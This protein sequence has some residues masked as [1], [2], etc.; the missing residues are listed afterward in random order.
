MA[1]MKNRKLLAESIVL[2]L[3][4]SLPCG[5]A[6]AA[7]IQI[8]GNTSYSGP[9]E[10][11]AGGVRISS[12][13]VLSGTKDTDMVMSGEFSGY[14]RAVEVDG[15]IQTAKSLMVNGGTYVVAGGKISGIGT[16]TLTNTVN[17]HSGGSLAESLNNQGT[18]TDVDQL[19]LGGYVTNSGTISA[20]S[21]AEAD[22][23]GSSVFNI[24]NQE[25]GSITV[26]GTANLT[27]LGNKGIFNAG[28]INLDTAGNGIHNQVNGKVTAGS[29]TGDGYIHNADSSTVDADC[30]DV[31]EIS[32]AAGATIITDAITANTFQNSGTVKASAAATN[33]VLGKLTVGSF[34][35][36]ADATL[37]VND[38]TVTDKLVNSGTLAVDKIG[39]A[40]HAASVNN[41]TG[42]KLTVSGDVTAGKFENHGTA[43]L[44]TISADTVW[45]GGAFTANDFNAKTSVTNGT[46]GNMTV[47]KIGSAENSVALTNSENS[48]ITVSG[49]VYGNF[50][51]NGTMKV[52]G[53]VTG[54]GYFSRNANA[55]LEADKL[56]VTSGWNEINGTVSVNNMDVNA[57][58]AVLTDKL[59]VNDT[60]NVSANLQ[61]RAESGDSKLHNVN[62]NEGASLQVGGTSLT[63]DNV[64]VTSPDA[65]L[66]TYDYDAGNTE[67]DDKTIKVTGALT[68]NEGAALLMT[69]Q[70]GDGSR[71]EVGSLALGDGATL[72]NIAT[73][74]GEENETSAFTNFNVTSME[75]NH[76][77]LVN[78]GTMNIGTLSGE[79]NTIEVHSLV[80]GQVSI[81]NN[82]STGLQ[83]TGTS[84]ATDQFDGDDLAGSLQ[85]L[86]DTVSIE[87]GSQLDSVLAQEGKIF[88]EITAGVDEDGR[89]ITG[90]V[91]EKGNLANEGIT[92]LA[93]VALMSWRAD[94]D[95]MHQRMGELRSSRGEAGVWARMKRGESESGDLGIKNQYNTYQ[96][97]YDRKVGDWYVGG[98][99]SR[100]EGESRF[101]TGSG[102]N[103]ATG[104]TLYG[105]RVS[106]D[107]QYVDISA[108][109][110][111]LDNDFD[112]WGR[113]GIPSSGD[114]S[115][116]GYAF[117]AEYGKRFEAGGDFWIEP[118]VELT[119]GHLSS[120]DYTTSR[121]VHAEQD[122]MDSVV[123]RVG[124]AAGRDIRAGNVY[125]KASYLYD[126]D[127][128]TSVHMTD[129]LNSADYSQDLGGS[130]FEFG[131]GA[132]LNLNDTSH[133]YVDLERA[134]GG[135]VDTPWQWTAGL[136]FDF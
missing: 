88:G 71:V 20:G 27:Q 65:E 50:N 17:S 29:I 14:P 45:N 124:F 76:S 100:T 116:N 106:E 99:V 98:A 93:N 129:G 62:L 26:T 118:Q 58:M 87:S 81:E 105:T 12:G 22:E 85:S 54:T 55:L 19:L 82:T 13:A 57:I 127:G 42:A 86:A 16:V 48:T 112:V 115:N 77:T 5:M 38:L 108:K 59:T 103:K 95:E 21:L 61:F 24:G 25:S 73:H 132:N 121:G 96:L 90:S 60:T 131:L 136:R 46:G 39:D 74:V 64:T 134:V 37:T 30:I 4:L 133:L 35:N 49:D 79:G 67:N 102:E 114:Y 9:Y 91:V 66:S 44:Q 51:N 7:D 97:G 3:I 6:H 47:D 36:G 130:W 15:T 92:E 31:T 120:A 126:F 83:V 135:D 117:S 40:E 34:T 72:S 89:I 128:E 63:M 94:N 119:Y 78:E 10:N 1:N 104:F 75:G 52:D 69:N 32:N 101:A 28:T 41:G 84:A 33:N 23:A 80:G 111:R 125:V 107:G 113:G 123:G 122:A 11:T 8:S 70:A 56:V 68:V 43:D 53:T 110:A 109:Y 18:I 2:G